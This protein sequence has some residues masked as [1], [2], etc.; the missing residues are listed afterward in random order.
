MTST[1][2]PPASTKPV[3][4]G[5]DGGPHL[6][7]PA[8]SLAVLTVVAG[9]VGGSGPRPDTGPADVLAYTAAHPVAINL[10]AVLLFG[11]AFPLVVYAA[12][13]LRRLR[14]LGV[15]APGPVMGLTGSVLAAG[16][17]MTSALVSWT[18]GQTAG[19]NDPALAKVLATLWFATGGI[20]CVAPFGL[21]LAGI[22]VPS[23]ILNLLPRAL[24]WAGLVIGGLAVL[25]TFALF[26]DALY[27]LIPIGRFGGLL[28]LI[29]VSIL[30]PRTHPRR[31]P[32]AQG[33]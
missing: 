25:S 1:S 6:L 27:V 30:L 19:L 2:T 16:A 15:A 5:R 13:V 32:V 23:L 3:R 4:R 17:L 11:S 22:S 14:K 7:I 9:I 21:L 12:T 10:G 29:A 28:F 31:T 33:E 8:L 20:G 18:A 26:T 24:S